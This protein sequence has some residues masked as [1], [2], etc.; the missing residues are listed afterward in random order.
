MPKPPGWQGGAGTFAFMIGLGHFTATE[1][2]L[3]QLFL[4][5]PS[6]EH[7]LL[8]TLDQILSAFDIIVTFNGKSFDVPLMTSR[9]ILQKHPIPFSR[10][11]AY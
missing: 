9:Y 7:A 8:V 10:Q 3:I 2:K 6:Q 5:D 4:R 1:F 11:R